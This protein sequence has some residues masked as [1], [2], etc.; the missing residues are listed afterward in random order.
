LV[1]R[2]F[3]QSVV[4]VSGDTTASTGNCKQNPGNA[5][6]PC[7]IA[8]GEGTWRWQIVYSDANNTVTGACGHESFVINNDHPPCTTPSA[9]S[10]PQR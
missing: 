9:R 4:G 10:R 7:F 8:T 5:D 6:P 1:N 3:A 2:V